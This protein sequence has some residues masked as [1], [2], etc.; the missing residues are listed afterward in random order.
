MANAGLSLVGFMNEA[1]AL[2]HLKRAC[3]PAPNA[4]DATLKADWQAAKSKLGPAVTNAGTPKLQPI[5]AAGMLYIQ[6]LL[7]LPW[8]VASFPGPL[9]ITAANFHLVEIDPLLAF[10]LHVDSVRSANR[11]AGLATPPTLDQMLAIC[12]PT[13]QPS[14]N[15]DYQLLGQ[16]AIMKAKTLNLRVFE[17]GIIQ[18]KVAG[19]TFGPALP[20]VLVSRL[21]NR[22]YLSNG[23][24]RAIGLRKAGALY[25]PCLV[26]DVPNAL[27]VG[28]KPPN[29]SGEL[30][31]FSEALLSSNDPPTVGHLSRGCAF[32]VRLREVSRILHVTWAEYVW[33]EE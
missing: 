7:T 29:Q 25:M 2:I 20:F 8:V 13:A 1:E 9:A 21:N 24:H 14:E 3:I 17:A 26:R 19:L 22:F 4:D 27:A 12:L 5:P 23:Y 30:V 28:I 31:T 10:Q 16:S 33:P 11:C 15:F 32:D 6:A 18:G